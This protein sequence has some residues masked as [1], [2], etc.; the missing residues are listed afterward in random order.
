MKIAVDAQLLITKEKTGIG[1]N[2]YNMLQAMLRKNQAEFRLDY[3]SKPSGSLQEDVLLELQK[4]G[5]QLNGCS[6]FNAPLYKSLCE[7]LPLQHKW[8]FGNDSY[9]DVYHFINYFVPPYIDRKANVVTTIHDTAFKVYPETVPKKTRVLMELSLPKTCTRAN[10][11][12]TVS[13]FSKQE[14][15]KY[16]GVNPD[17]I[18]VAYNG[19]DLTK[20]HPNYDNAAIEQVKKN[21]G[22]NREYFLYVGTLE[23]RKN[24]E[25][26]IDAYTLLK[27]RLDNI[28]LLVLAGRK[29]WMY[30]T[31]FEKI[32]KL[33]LEK[34]VLF[35]GYISAQE[36]PLLMSGALAFLFVSLYEGF[37]MPPLEAMA[38]GT[39]TLVSDCSS[40]PEVVGKSALLADPL[41]IEAI[42]EKM[43][44]LLNDSVLRASLAKS[45][46]E[47]AQQF[48]WD[49]PAIKLLNLFKHLSQ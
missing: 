26:L 47:R 49:K 48:D 15:V 31:I 5:C 25:R 45:G 35:S 1:W 8:F 23:P 34:D 24:I 39:P 20:F 42:A 22:I 30:G 4:A 6:Y 13:E 36:E 14:I 17:K 43:E 40:L 10:A 18:M 37:G 27:S 38:C 19:V 41:S 7:F 2:A 29:G 28:P 3:F 33:H 44:L 9:I 12:V 16:L 21:F 32:Q 46:I 11:I